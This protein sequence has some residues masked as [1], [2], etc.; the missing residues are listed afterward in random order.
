VGGA[1]SNQKSQAWRGRPKKI[2][3]SKKI[4]GEE[5]NER[6]QG[7][8]GDLWVTKE[9]EAKSIDH[10]VN[11]EKKKQRGWHL[12]QMVRSCRDGGGWVWRGKYRKRGLIKRQDG[13]GE[14][15]QHSDWAQETVGQQTIARR[16]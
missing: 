8:L 5:K 12:R 16:S 14:V 4:T 9:K 2:P 11:E 3:D 10:Y 1:V 7:L 6:G 13:K 15:K